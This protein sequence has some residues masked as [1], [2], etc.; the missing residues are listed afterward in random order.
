MAM[1]LFRQV[2]FAVSHLQHLEICHRDRM[3]ENIFLSSCVQMKIADFGF[4][5]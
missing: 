3:P 1:D 4:A 2:V 5:R